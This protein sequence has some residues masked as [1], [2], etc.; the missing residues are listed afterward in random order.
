[1]SAI[2]WNNKV[3]DGGTTPEGIVSAANM[4]EIKGAVNDNDSR[5]TVIESVEGNIILSLA[6][7]PSPISGVITL[8]QD[9]MGYLFKGLVDISPNVIEITGQNVK[10][11]GT[12]LERDG[13]TT[14]A[15][16]SIIT[17]TTSNTLFQDISIE[18]PNATEVFSFTNS[19]T[20]IFQLDRVRLVTTGKFGTVTNPASVSV[21]DC[22]I[23][24]TTAPLTIAGTNIFGRFVN[25]LGFAHTGALLDLGTA[26]FSAI[27]IGEN[28]IYGQVAG[29]SFLTI[30]NDGANITPEGE[31][32]ISRN[33]FIDE[34]GGLTAINGSYVFSPRWAV[35]LNTENI[36][37][38][39][40]ILPSGWANYEDTGTLFTPA[41]APVQITI[42]GLGSNTYSNKLPTS[43]RGTGQLWDTSTSKITPITEDDTYSLRIDLE[44]TGSS[45][46]PTRF[47]VRLDIGPTPDGT[48]VGPN[49][50]LIVQNSITLKTGSFPQNYSIAFPIFD[51]STFLANGGTLWV[52]ADSGDIDVESR[53]IFIKRTGSGAS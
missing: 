3:E 5:V 53:S 19:N 43:I 42:A 44:V 10:V 30:A 38:S 4:N 24:G 35:A 34:F 12:Y 51:R 2:T 31:G 11:K 13:I 15:S 26:T 1:M 25:S 52:S 14:T 45:G 9:D 8:D 41:A 36:L 27:D 37:S 16:G 22:L 23:V 47:D 18:A 28:A 7:L 48:G 40:R 32:T 49:S 20:K 6:D 29:A 17:N 21:F 50:I 33:K 46:N 39:D